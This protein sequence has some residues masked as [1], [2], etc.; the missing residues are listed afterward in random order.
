MRYRK[1]DAAVGTQAAL[2][3]LVC[4]DRRAYVA[5]SN[6]VRNDSGHGR[7]E[8]LIPTLNDQAL[9]QELFQSLVIPGH[10]GRPPTLRIPT[11]KSNPSQPERTIA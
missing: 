8:H 6:S 7:Q 1:E 2:K 3:Q 10:P 4:P 5:P 11:P 9:S